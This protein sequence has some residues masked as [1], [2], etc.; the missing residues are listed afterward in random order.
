MWILHFLPDSFIQFIVHTILLAG[1]IGCF[2][3]FFVINKILRFFPPFASYYKIAQIVSV[4][5]LVSGIYFE[6]GY[7]T[8]MQWRERVREM[9]AKVAKAEEESKLANEELD[10]KVVAKVKVIQGRQVVVKQYIDREITK[11]NNQC[12]IPQEFIKAHNDSAE[13][14][15]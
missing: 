6:G 1:I 15:K 10:K 13:Q 5:L 12:V 3:S 7:S 2:L 14:P 4:A 11:Y 9:E 8:E